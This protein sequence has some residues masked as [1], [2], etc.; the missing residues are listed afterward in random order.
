MKLCLPFLFLFIL[1]GFYPSQAQVIQKDTTISPVSADDNAL[2]E[3][4]KGARVQSSIHESPNKSIK[5][6]FDVME[7]GLQY[8]IFKNETKVFSKSTLGLKLNNNVD[9]YTNLQLVNTKITAVSQEMNLYF[10]EKRT[11]SNSYTN[12][13][14]E[15][16]KKEN[17]SRK[18]FIEFRLYE[19]GF[20]FRYLIPQQS[21]LSTLT[22][23][24]E[25]S[26]F[27]FADTDV[28]IQAETGTETGYYT[29]SLANYA[30]DN[31]LPSTLKSKSYY[32]SI[33][34]ANNQNFSRVKLY[35]NKTN[36]LATRLVSG[37]PTYT[38]EFVSPWRYVLIAQTASEL[39]NN[40]YLL[41]KLN[42]P[43]QLQDL[44]WIKPGKV[45]RVM[46]LD[47]Q[48]ALEYIDFAKSMNLQ[49][50]L[51]DAGWYGLGYSQES[52]PASDPRKVIATLNMPS[53]INY[54]TKNGIGVLLYVNEVALKNYPVD[55][56]LALYKSWGIKGLKL[57]FVEGRTQQGIQFQHTMLKKAI[58]HK[59][60]I[61]IHDQFRPTGTSLTYPNF[62]TVEGVRGNEYRTNTATHTTTLPFTRFLTGAADYTVCYPDPDGQNAALTVLKTT[63]AH[64]L[65]LSVAFFSPLQHTLWYGVPKHYNQPVEIEFFKALPTVWDDTRYL[66]GEIGKFVVV[67]RRKGNKWFVSVLNGEASRQ[68]SVPLGFMKGENSYQAIS[69]E[70]S[71][72]SIARKDFVVS[73]QSSLTFSLN[74][75][76]GKVFII[77][78][79]SFIE[80]SDSVDVDTTPIEVE[81]PLASE[82]P[83][84][85]LFKVYPNP[86]A[87][88]VTIHSKKMPLQDHE[89]RIVDWMGR[90]I[91]KNK[92]ANTESYEVNLE[93]Y[94]AGM[95]LLLIYDKQNQL[96]YTTKVVRE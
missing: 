85:D 94:S 93:K 26:E 59:F 2:Y 5:L 52:N 18:L 31:E 86:T 14:F 21:N 43:S 6:I 1:S 88:K 50:I 4:R 49:Y 36:S 7:E 73:N 57:G 63:K 83:T 90:T 23:S 48:S 66:D 19:E 67:A 84:N 8:Q 60:V 75:S 89:V 11:L 82:P 27:V 68:F 70:D 12:V 92:I 96:I 9:F 62:L 69:Y 15:F 47:T 28:T 80:P 13:I 35:R 54:A 20:A 79:D 55:E 30:N 22:I 33:N 81:V 58:D 95:Y 34:E 53:I 38:N 24:N 39:A 32:Y 42:E 87:Q 78:S 25:L 29:A 64:Q 91:L 16:S 76:S 71:N 74:G 61:N 10:N 45:I 44:S 72:K 46:N 77:E 65:A 56:C 17:T 41:Y 3:K 40:K 37:N 51:F